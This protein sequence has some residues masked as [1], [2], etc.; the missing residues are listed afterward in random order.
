MRR[1]FRETTPASKGK[2]F[3]NTSNLRAHLKLHE[4][5]NAEADLQYADETDGEAPVTKKR[6]GGEYGRDWKCQTNG[7]DEDYKSV[8]DILSFTKSHPADPPCCPQKKA[9]QIHIDVEHQGRRD[10][11]CNHNGCTRSFA[12]KHLLQR[13]VA[14]EHASEHSTDHST[15]SE[16]HDT[17][18]EKAQN[19]GEDDF[20]ID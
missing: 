9:L 17:E 1:S 7:C 4:H 8:I 11:P 10:F 20:N 12:Y 5:R 15:S 13:H 6:R 2:I 18:Q 19:E 14:K 16:E 3:S